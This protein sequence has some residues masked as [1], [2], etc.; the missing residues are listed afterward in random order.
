[1]D[2]RVVAAHGEA[3]S[4]N[5]SG[6]QE[7]DWQVVVF[8]VPE[9]PTALLDELR[10]RLRLNEIDL[11]IRFHDL[12]G[13][14][15]ER[16]DA[17]QAEELA[18]AIRALGVDAEAIPSQAWPDLSHAPTVHHLRCA[19][20]G[21]EVVPPR[22]AAVECISWE[23]VAV[24]SIADVPLDVAHHFA[25]PRTVVVR[26]TPRLKDAEIATSIRGAEM[27]IVCEEPFEALRVDH[28]EMNYEYLGER[29]TDSATSNFRQF[30]EDLTRH[31]AGVYLTPTARAFLS[32]GRVEQYRL[33]SRERHRALVELHTVLA[34][35]LRRRAAGWKTS[36]IHDQSQEVT[37]NATR[38]P[39]RLERLMVLHEKL[40][41]EIEELKGWL[42]EVDELG[43]PMF[44]QLGDRVAALRRALA[45]HFAL[46][47]EG[48][49]MAELLDIAPH[50]ADRVAALLP[51][52]A[53]LLAEFDRVSRE[54]CKSPTTY[55]CWSIAEADF[56]QA[57]DRL[58]RH[59]HRENELWQEAYEAE[60][61]AVD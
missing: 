31:A 10:R 23:R 52:H 32:I 8:A 21:L 35:R 20:R 5:P 45:E 14:L 30:A 28:R 7:A 49:Y 11:R 36:D 6:T 17:L 41:H 16:L 19:P 44:G 34:R 60:T 53:E 51:E 22:G 47:E 9:E 54:L 1:M 12:P 38:T 43:R 58:E 3:V 61:G 48:G 4:G 13:I 57:L 26:V 40:N 29:K 55:E 15:P 50:L 2:P 33:E 18:G 24:V 46:E 42:H 27:W 59:E 37:M 25:P 39:Q 56:H